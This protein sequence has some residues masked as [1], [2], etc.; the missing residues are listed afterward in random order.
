MQNLFNTLS[1]ALASEN[2]SDTWQ[3]HF[4]PIVY[5]ETRSYTH[6]DGSKYGRFISITRFENG[7]YERPVHYLR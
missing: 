2:L 4:S 3:E 1:E 7:M 5:G 6:D